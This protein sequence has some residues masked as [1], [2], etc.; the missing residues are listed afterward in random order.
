VSETLDLR[1]LKCPEPAIRT[2]RALRDTEEL[3][4]L[5]DD[6]EAVQNIS[7]G[8][9]K[10]GF[11]LEVDEAEGAFRLHI[12][13]DAEADMDNIELELSC[14]LPGA[15]GGAVVFF[16]SDAVGNGDDEL[17]RILTK[18]IIYSLLEV[19]P[20]PETMVFMNSGVKLAIEGSESLDDLKALN[21]R[22]V[23]ILVCGTCLDYLGLKEKLA[24]GEVSNAYTISETLLGA[25]KVVRF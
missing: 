10:R 3:Y 17:G 21:D 20:A 25:G 4:V 7:R 22:G 9:K 2:G 16:P 14:E 11:G 1:G 19:E 6:E 8:V 23:E 18:S 24:V 12:T 5:V 13:R 15:A